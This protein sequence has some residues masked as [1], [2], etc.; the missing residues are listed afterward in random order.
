A[1]DISIDTR[2]ARTQYQVVLQGLNDEDLRTWSTQLIAELRR[3]AELSDVASDQQDNGL[4]KIVVVNRR[5][6]A[7]L[8]ITIAA[9]DQ[10]LYDAFGQRQ[11]T[12]IYSPLRPYHVVLE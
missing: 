2:A 10:I 1:Q 3:E 7:R 11:I 6:A 4:Q 12:T 5:A 8:G 9:I